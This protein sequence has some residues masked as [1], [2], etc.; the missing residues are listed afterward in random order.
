MFMQP[1]SYLV[2]T[3]KNNALHE[4]ILY[5]ECSKLFKELSRLGVKTYNKSR[6][7]DGEDAGGLEALVTN[8][9]GR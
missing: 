3:T 4:I 6:N 8:L 7:S 1:K 9:T 5:E 2:V